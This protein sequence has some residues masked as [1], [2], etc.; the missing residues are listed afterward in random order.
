MEYQTPEHFSC[1]G[2]M[3]S[4]VNST[5]TVAAFQET[6]SREHIHTICY[7]EEMDLAGGALSYEG[8]DVIGRVETG[9]LKRFRGSMIQSKSDIKRMAGMVEWFARPMCP[10]A[11]KQ[12]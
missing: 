10:F 12:G 7:F 4:R 9:G 1:T 5:G 11:I 2:Y 8:I 6:L 3:G